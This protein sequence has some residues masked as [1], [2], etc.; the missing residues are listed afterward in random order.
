MAKPTNGFYHRKPE[1]FVSVEGGHDWSGYLVRVNLSANLLGVIRSIRPGIDQVPGFQAREIP[2]ELSLRGTRLA[3]R[4]K[5][6]DRNPR[7]CDPRRAA[8]N[9]SGLLDRWISPDTVPA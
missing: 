9:S 7:T 2:Q 1:V 8:A 6:P 5:L 3:S 4:D